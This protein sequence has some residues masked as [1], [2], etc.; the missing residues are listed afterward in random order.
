MEFPMNVSLKCYIT[1][2]LNPTV[3]MNILRTALCR[4]TRTGGVVVQMYLSSYVVLVKRNAKPDVVTAILCQL[5]LDACVVER[6]RERERERES[7]ML[8]NIICVNTLVTYAEEFLCIM[9]SAVNAMLRVPCTL[10]V[11]KVSL[12]GKGLNDVPAYVVYFYQ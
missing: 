4:H 5:A 10:Q 2:L 12:F 6:E 3:T 7:Q 11:Q 1:F 8:T 9:K